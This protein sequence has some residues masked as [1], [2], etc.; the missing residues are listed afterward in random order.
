MPGKLTDVLNVAPLQAAREEGRG[1][2]RIA[3]P[4]DCVGLRLCRVAG[5]RL[6]MCE[7][8]VFERGRDGVD[9]VLRRA[10]ISG[11][12]GPIGEAGDYWAD[13]LTSPDIWTDTIALDAASYRALKYHWMRCRVQP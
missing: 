9:I 11:R 12:V 3:L 13:L 7:P 2:E 10:S 4:E 1:G 6:V 5:G 8:V